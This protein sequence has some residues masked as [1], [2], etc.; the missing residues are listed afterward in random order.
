MAVHFL[1]ALVGAIN[2]SGGVY[3]VPEPDYISWPEVEMDAT[4]SAGM[5]VSRVDGAGT[6]MYPH[7]RYLLHRLPA[8][9]NASQNSPVQLLF[10]NGANPVYS[11][12]DSGA[13]AKAFA[14]I[15]MVVSFSSFM[16]ET[17]QAADLILPNHMALERYEEVPAA[18][19][20]AKPILGLAR[21]A[22]EPQFNTRHVGDVIIELANR[23][24]GPIA[25]AFSWDSYAVCLEETLSEV[26]E[27]LTE[28]GYRAADDTEALPFETESGKFEFSNRDLASLPAY[29]PLAPEGDAGAYPLVLIPYNSMRLPAGYIGAP[30]FLMKAL[31]DTILQGNDVLVEINP[32][33]AR[34]MKLVDGKAAVLETPR[35]KAGVRV[36][37]T[38]G[39][40]PG[41]VA[42]PRG[43][44]HKAHNRFLAE[45]GVNF[46]S[47]V[48]PVEDP[49]SGFDAL[50]GIRA[51]LSRA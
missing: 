23:M 36:R 30:P 10:V 5:Q 50:W 27:D 22:V 7:A 42:L 46:N 35:G 9:I 29:A 40:M 6:A 51:K 32:Q 1:N 41:V 17:A 12:A 45:K 38:E 3:A 37:Y 14:K 18:A 13:L 43:L 4:A 16:D 31:E 20:F 15:P 44:G 47:L 39:I 26:W 34:E 8:S 24:G 21:P 19:G 48:A 28:A 49:A 11:I 2:R 33:T 25:S